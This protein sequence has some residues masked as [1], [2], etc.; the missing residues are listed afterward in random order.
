MGVIPF[1]IGLLISIR[2]LIYYFQGLGAG[3]V[4]SLILASVL[5]MLGWQTVM[6][7]LQADIIA[8]NRKLLQDVQFRVRK[9]EMRNN[10]CE[11]ED[12]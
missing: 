2:F 8:A 7:G 10:N 1:G 11:K 6:M 12:N 9:I 4:Q 5:L 3:H